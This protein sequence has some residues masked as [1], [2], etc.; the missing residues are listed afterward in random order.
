MSNTLNLR[1]VL[2]PDLIE[3]A[4]GPFRKPDAA[5]H[6]DAVNFLA[7]EVLTRL[8]LAHKTAENPVAHP[9]QAEVTALCEVL[10]QADAEAALR[11]LLHAHAVGVPAEDLSLQYLAKAARQLGEWWEED[12]VSATEVVLATGLI[13]GILRSLHRLLS[14]D[15]HQTQPDL[16]RAFFASAPGETHTLGIT[17]AA[18]H[19]RK[20]GW[21]IVLRTQMEHEPLVHEASRGKWPVIGLT[22]SCSRMIFPLA[23]LIIGLR[24]SNPGSWIMICGKIT[25][26]EPDIA[27]LVDADAVTNDLDEA[28]ALMLGRLKQQGRAL[29]S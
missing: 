17:M 3:R 7:R 26:L 10:L 22:G 20:L 19:F 24:V 15:A 11:I 29:H 25:D 18:D 9:T 27:T 13:Y 14:D 12:R 2:D 28:E 16:Y 21:N 1:E 4:R 5:R 23:R 8:D 6:E